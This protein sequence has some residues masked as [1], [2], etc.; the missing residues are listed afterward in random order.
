MVVLVVLVLVVVAILLVE[1]V[2]LVVVIEERKKKENILFNDACNKFYLCIP[3]I[4]FTVIKYL[5]YD[6]PF[7]QYWLTRIKRGI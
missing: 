3:Q 1:V 2:L 5:V 4:L 7:V 6:T